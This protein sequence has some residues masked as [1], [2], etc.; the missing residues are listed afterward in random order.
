[1][2]LTKEG[3]DDAKAKVGCAQ[4][5]S[6]SWAEQKAMNN[7]LGNVQQIPLEPGGYAP[8]I[9]KSQGL[10]LSIVHGLLEGIFAHGQT[11]VLISRTPDG[12]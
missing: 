4:V 1:M 8:S 6:V 3:V 11:Y 12:G 10:T 9:H 7:I 5:T 2:H